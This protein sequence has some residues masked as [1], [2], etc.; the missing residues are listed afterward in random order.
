MG[1]GKEE[2]ELREGNV[3]ILNLETMAE[4]AKFTDSKV[5]HSLVVLLIEACGAYLDLV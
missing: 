3:M 1:A 2:K 4:T 5:S